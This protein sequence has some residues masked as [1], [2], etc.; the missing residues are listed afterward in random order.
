MQ[1]PARRFSFRGCLCCKEIVPAPRRRLSSSPRDSHP[2][3]V[4][5]KAGTHTP[6]SH[7]SSQAVSQAGGTVYGSPPSRGRLF[8]ASAMTM[9]SD[10]HGAAPSAG[11]ATVT[12]PQDR[13]PQPASGKPHRI[14][15]HHHIAPPKFV[16]EL[17][18]LLQPPT[19]NWSA[20]R[21]IEDMD[22]A[23]VATAIT[24]ITTPGVWIGDDGQ[25]ARIAR[26]CN[27]YAAQLAADHPGR[28]GLFVALPL[29]NIEASLREIEYGLDVLKA[30]G[31]ALFTS[32]RDKWLG[33]PAFEPV[34]AELNRRKAV[35][36]THPEAPLCC[37]GLFP[38]VNDSVIEYGTDTSRA[39]LR[40]LC[41]GTAFRYRDI[42]WIFSHGG[43]TMPFLAERFVRAPNLNKSF[44]QYLP[45][46]VMAELQRFHYDVA[47]VAYPPALAALTRM[48]P[49]SQILWG[50]D[51]P[52]RFG[53]EYVKGL[54]EFGFRAEDLAK[55]DRENAL[56]LLPRWR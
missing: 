20:Q 55:I 8:G 3:V 51:F 28:F 39:I 25:G 9:S 19:L 49:I 38:D 35:A 37:R 31:V 21:S 36:Y 43:G 16:A 12:L 18:S 4:P 40:I 27:D 46:G 11:T 47:Q 15:V 44:Q 33:D 17:R 34:M 26:E 50:T 56:T 53:W 54:A 41:T 45:D 7:D 30:D 2:Y 13:T 48:I 32:Y 10:G 22:R 42:Q 5:A 29:P 14:D 23:G 1:G 6:F 52:F 24:S